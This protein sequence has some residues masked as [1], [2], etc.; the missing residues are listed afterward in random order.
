V[1]LLGFLAA[2]A[3]VVLA[4]GGVVAALTIYQSRGTYIG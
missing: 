1:F 2:L 4:V 3:L